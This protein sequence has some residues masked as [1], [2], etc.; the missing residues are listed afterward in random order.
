MTLPL[1]LEDPV[2]LH[3]VLDDVLS[4]AIDPSGEGHKQ[5]LQGGGV[6]NHSPILPCPTTGRR[7]DTS[8]DDS[9]STGSFL[10][11]FWLVSMPGLR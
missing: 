9:D 11:H 2:L 5:D 10:N 6:G 8:A 1:S 7:G 4:V 3:Q